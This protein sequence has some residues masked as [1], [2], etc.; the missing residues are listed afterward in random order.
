MSKHTE[1]EQ[2]LIHA[3]IDVY[4]ELI[5]SRYNYDILLAEGKLKKDITPEIVLSIKNFFLNDVYPDAAKRHQIEAAFETLGSYV[6]QPAKAMGLFGSVTSAIFIFGRH[7]PAAINAGVVTLQSFLEARKLE[8]KMLKAAKDNFLQTDLTLE[9][10]KRCI[11]SIPQHELKDFIKDVKEMF[12][13]MSDTELL[14]KTIRIIDMVIEKMKAKPKLY[15][16]EEVAG[17]VLGR[18]ILQNGLNLFKN[19]NPKLK[20]AIAETIY[21]VEISFLNNLYSTYKG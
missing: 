2:E 5:G 19:Y 12:L 14:E 11:A 15:S 13:L 16:A 4:R 20:K 8:H 9:D 1:Q 18:N 21:D 3:I 7:L 10:M 6:S 17:I